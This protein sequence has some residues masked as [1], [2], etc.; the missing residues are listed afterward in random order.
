MSISILLICFISIFLNLCIL[1]GSKLKEGLLKSVL[2]FSAMVVFITEFTSFFQ[3]LNFKFVLLF[4]IG[5][6]VLNIFYSLK[7]RKKIF[8]FVSK[9][10]KS[11]ADTFCDLN[12]SEK[13]LLSAVI[14][15]LVLIFIQGIVYPPN[16]WDS[17]T[18]HLARIPNWISHQSVAHY[19][20][21]IF[22]QIYQPP[23]SEFVIMHFN[24]L[25]RGDYFSNSV[26]FFYLIFSL[27]AIVL[28]VDLFGLSRQ[29][30]I[31]ALVL[32]VS[33]PEVILQA[34][35]TQNDIV[36]SF[37]ILSTV[38]F[39]VKSVKQTL[40][41]NYLFLG[42]SIG[43]AVLTKATA[44]L[45][46]APVLLFFSIS[47]LI[48]LYKTKKIACLGYSFFAA[49]IS[50]IINL[51][52]FIRNYNLANNILGVDKTESRMYSNE[53][54][55]P[56]L[57]VS[58][59]IKNVGLH[60]GTFPFYKLTN[61]IIYKLHSLAGVDV[62]NPGTNFLNINYNCGGTILPTHEDTA[63]NTIQFLLIILSLILI[64]LNI[65]KT[66]TVFSKI[67]LYISLLLLQA[68]LF[69]F[70][71]K[72]QPWHTR[73]HTPLF[74]LSVPMV[75][76]AINLNYKFVKIF[77]KIIPIIIFSAFIIILFNCSRP[78]ISN[79]FTKIISIT[80]N[81]YKKY[82][83]DRPNL[84]EEY[85]STVEN[86]NKMNYKNIGILLGHEDWEYPLYSQF[87]GKG[88]NP[89]HINVSNITNKYFTNFKKIDCI[90]STTVNDSVINYNG[91]RFHNLNPGNKIIWLYK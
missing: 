7:K 51:G 24:I 1:S 62:N 69:C 49:I 17:M 30:K 10:K 32:T 91:I 2:A 42:L 34:S 16:N 45:Y 28:I 9:E 27:F 33:I 25:N 68:A 52:P 21:H 14:A 38:Y 76:Y 53:N 89:I 8:E 40:F 66:K 58:N 57:F 73:L 90:V 44:Y 46:L 11:I 85:N 56:V 82:F 84:Y 23:F 41:Q 78:Y 6:S 74:M 64:G 61:K 77:Y 70:F 39:A 47:V 31:I 79:R 15:I 55:T 88:I 29:Y 37:F 12:K 35:S 75:C 80:D 20:T 86:I 63:A 22:R 83:A 43:L 54:M 13:F 26:Q 59:V 71:L 4:W 87:Y 50:I 3:V 19:P 18:Y 81:R 65:L 72:W 5:V 60:F 67:S 36:V 48:N